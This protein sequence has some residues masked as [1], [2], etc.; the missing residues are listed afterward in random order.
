MP[1]QPRRGN[2]PAGPARHAKPSCRRP[3]NPPSHLPLSSQ[4]TL[5]LPQKPLNAFQL[6]VQR[7]SWL[8]IAVM[9]GL[10]PVVVLLSGAGP[11]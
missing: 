2:T 7:V 3:P 4:P 9:A 11:P 10:V 6:G 5:A 1:K 8:L